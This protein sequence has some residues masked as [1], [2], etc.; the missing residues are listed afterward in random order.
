MIHLVLLT[1]EQLA[2]QRKQE[3]SRL[4][5]EEG[6]KQGKGALGLGTDGPF[7]LSTDHRTTDGHVAVLL[8]GAAGVRGRVWRKRAFRLCDVAADRKRASFP[9][10]GACVLRNGDRRSLKAFDELTP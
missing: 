3:S 4:K 6:G 8:N 1:E 2:F 10:Q 5:L 7:P 9:G